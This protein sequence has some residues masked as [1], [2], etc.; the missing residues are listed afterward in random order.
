MCSQ[1]TAASQFNSLLISSRCSVVV[2][3][4]GSNDLTNHRC[5]VKNFIELLHC[6][7][8]L[9]VARYHLQKVVLMEILHFELFGTTWAS[10][11]KSTMRKWMPATANYINYLLRT[12]LQQSPPPWTDIEPGTPPRPASYASVTE[13]VSSTNESPPPE[14]IVILWSNT[15]WPPTPPPPPLSEHWTF[16]TVCLI[17]CWE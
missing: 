11:L 9:T 7:V 13:P 2:L 6:N 16:R 15:S 8:D 1:I 5:S 3:Q 4:I 14:D 10:L 12:C 17:D